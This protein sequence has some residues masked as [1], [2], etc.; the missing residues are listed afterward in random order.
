MLKDTKVATWLH[1]NTECDFALQGSEFWF[2]LDDTLR[3]Y[4]GTLFLG[5]YTIVWLLVSASYVMSEDLESDWPDIIGH[6]CI[7]ELLPVVFQGHILK[8][9]HI[10][11]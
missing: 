7:M 5:C 6:A 9:F 3:L 11:F 1:K 4:I 8:K 2:L 10:N